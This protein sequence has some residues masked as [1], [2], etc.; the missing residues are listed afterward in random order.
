MPYMISNADKTIVECF[1]EEEFKNFIIE[2]TNLPDEERLYKNIDELILQN[3]TTFIDI[4]EMLFPLDKAELLGGCEYYKINN[5]LRSRS[6]P[7]LPTIIKGVKIFKQIYDYQNDKMFCLFGEYH[8]SYEQTV[9]SPVEIYLKE[10]F[11]ASPYYIDFF[12]EINNCDDK[13]IKNLT[14]EQ[15]SNLGKITRI[16]KM[17]SKCFSGEDECQYIGRFHIADFRRSI[18]LNNKK[19]ISTIYGKFYVVLFTAYN[20]IINNK[21]DESVIVSFLNYVKKYIDKYHIRENP[22]DFF[23]AL[24]AWIF[25]IFK[26][27][28]SL[29]NVNKYY[30]LTFMRCYNNI[31]RECIEKIIIQLNEDDIYQ[32]ILSIMELIS[33]PIDIIT[34]C[35][36]YQATPQIKNP[37]FPLKNIILYTG[38]FH[39][40]TIS[41]VLREL[42]FITLIEKK[43]K[44]DVIFMENLD[45]FKRPS[46]E[47]LDSLLLF[48]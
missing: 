29:K 1:T 30:Q 28:D 5:I 37:E 2:Q 39:T 43:E 48:P 22:E 27:D 14:Y 33:V 21:D 35:K 13:Y 17:F 25:E 9:G 11:S 6:F 47:Y 20:T 44:H 31:T 38:A 7:S 12:L 45:I 36:I 3:G 40:Q 10:L 15:C 26:I 42:G 32:F 24:S 19:F 46:Q 23:K 8:G 34:L 4:G 16:H 41:H 18:M